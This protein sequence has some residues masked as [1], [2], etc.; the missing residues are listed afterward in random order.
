MLSKKPFDG[1]ALVNRGIIQNQDQQGL[2][3]P[4]MQLMEKLKKPLGGAAGCPLPIEAL[5]AE[6]QRPKHR[7]T[8]TLGWGRDFD[9]MA[10]AKPPT[11]DVGFIGKMR[12]IDKQD[13]YRLLA[14]A[15]ADG[16]DDF[17][18]PG[19]FFAGLGALPGIV[20]AKRL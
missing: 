6:M 9:L 17:C 7:G 3:K 18:H 15:D 14:L 12:L 11:L 4:L 19:F 8:L 16:R 5:G 10:L 13:F 1:T 2:G 20:L